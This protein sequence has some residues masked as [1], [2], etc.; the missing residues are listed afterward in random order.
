MI[1]SGLQIDYST[2]KTVL[3]AFA[4]AFVTLRVMGYARKRKAG[5]EREQ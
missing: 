1:M 4:S 2:M 5:S 3:I